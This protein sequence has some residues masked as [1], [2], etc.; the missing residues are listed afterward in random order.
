MTNPIVNVPPVV[1]VLLATVYLADE[2]VDTV[3]TVG[4]PASNTGMSDDCRAD[5]TSAVGEIKCKSG[6]AAASDLAGA[7]VID[8]C[9]KAVRKTTDKRK[10]ITTCGNVLETTVP[11]NVDAKSKGADSSRGLDVVADLVCLSV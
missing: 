6:G 4:V 1:G 7:G 10:L 5:V 3:L 11:A 2:A 9:I 8:H